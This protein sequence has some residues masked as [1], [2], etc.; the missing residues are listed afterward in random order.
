[1]SETVRKGSGGTRKY[2]RNLVKCGQYKSEDRCF[3][4]KVRRIVR[5]IKHYRNSKNFLNGIKDK[6]MRHEIQRRLEKVAV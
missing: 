2:G 6:I 4:N 3:K 5:R 1:M